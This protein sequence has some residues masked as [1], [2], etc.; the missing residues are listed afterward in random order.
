[1]VSPKFFE[2]ERFVQFAVLSLLYLSLVRPKVFIAAYQVTLSTSG[3]FILLQLPA[4]IG[5]LVCGVSSIFEHRIK[6][7]ARRWLL[8]LPVSAICVTFISTLTFYFFRFFNNTT[9]ESV[10]FSF[11]DIA[12]LIGLFFWA[13]SFEV[14]RIR[15]KLRNGKIGSVESDEF[16]AKTMTRI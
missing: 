5:G 15:V 12:V 11:V 10:W 2:R 3:D 7:P 6:P 16:D 14:K 9:P 13:E 8:R 1:M 4:F